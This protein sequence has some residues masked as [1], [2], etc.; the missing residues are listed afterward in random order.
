[1]YLIQ[2]M[3]E[4]MDIPETVDKCAITQN[5]LLEFVYR[6]QN[7]QECSFDVKFLRKLL[8]KAIRDSYISKEEQLVILTRDDIKKMKKSNK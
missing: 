4:V 8:I 6:N 2:D 5:E 3:K 1:M 7:N